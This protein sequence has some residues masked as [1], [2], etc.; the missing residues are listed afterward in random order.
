MDLITRSD[1]ER[2]EQPKGTKISDLY[3]QG[4]LSQ[5]LAL[6]HASLRASLKRETAV[7]AERDA[8]RLI[9]ARAEDVEKLAYIIE[10]AATVGAVSW[11]GVARAVAEYMKEG[12]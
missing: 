6:L 9:A 7:I 8:L 4:I 12:K 3:S 10:D 11:K 2:L 5:W 1:D